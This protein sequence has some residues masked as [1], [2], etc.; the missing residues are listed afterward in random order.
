M[1]GTATILKSLPP[2][3]GVRYDVVGR[4]T[5]QDIVVGMD[6]IHKMT[7]DHYDNIARYFVGST[8]NRTLRNLFDFIKKN[9]AYVE[10]SDRLQTVKTPAAIIA[11]GNTYGND[12]KNYSLFIGGVL[13]AINRSGKQRIPF[14]YRF[15]S[16][17]PK[18]P[19]PGHVFV[20]AYPYTQLETWVDPVLD[21]FDER[22]QPEYF[23]DKNANT[24]LS[25]VTG[26][27]SHSNG[28]VNG[29]LNDILFAP[30]LKKEL[31][32][33]LDAVI[34]YMI[35]M[36]L[37]DDP[38]VNAR[39]PQVVK[40]KREAL[41][42]DLW[43]MGAQTNITVETDLYPYIRQWMTKYLKM[44][45]E[46]WWA[47]QLPGW[48]IARGHEMWNVAGMYNK[49]GGYADLYNQAVATQ[50][51]PET[52]IPGGLDMKANSKLMEGILSKIGPSLKWK[53]G[54]VAVWGPAESDWDGV[55]VNPIISTKPVSGGSG[56]SGGN[57]PDTG[58]K[59]DNTMLYI[60]GAVVVALLLFANKNKR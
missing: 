2:Y 37:P 17:K 40:N 55:A 35:Y 59:G 16:Y 44:E 48:G 38:A 18:Q 4:Q 29:F 8:A 47:E 9:S 21:H 52:G 23:Y 36:Y 32:D 60:G 58:N 43:N 26:V 54:G 45:P 57:L 51:V 49:V 22:L 28:S 15:A 50:G 12:C 13:D 42:H 46:K 53:N 56:G 10:E 30:G 34:P 31:F 24:M 14:V 3:K 39:L 5:V 11:E 27:P 25:V 41:M 19:I 7:A 33:S 20:V 6:W 1:I